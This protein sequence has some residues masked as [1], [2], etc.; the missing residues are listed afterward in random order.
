MTKKSHWYPLSFLGRLL[1]SLYAFVPPYLVYMEYAGGSSVL[2]RICVV[3]GM[4]IVLGAMVASKKS[5]QKPFL[6]KSPHSPE[7]AFTL[8][9]LLVVISII[10]ILAAI[11]LPFVIG[12]RKEAYFVRAK[13]E[14]R[15]IASALQI[16]VLNTNGQYPP[17]VSRD[18]PTGLEQYL[19]AGNWSKAPW[20][21]SVY[22][23][24]NWAPADLNYNPKAQ[25]YQISIRFCP[26]GEPENCN[27]PSEVWAEDFD[28]YSSMYYCIEGPCRSHSSK[29]QNHPGL[30]V[31]C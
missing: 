31:N 9:E 11:I 10:G 26:L 1:V 15:S 13:A 18:L 12:A 27:F 24:D 14:L 20:P 5:K 3:G 17:D 8:I 4:C 21:G 23:W 25:V 28:Y 30:C 29:P 2:L 7:G 6:K 22:D 16:Y 19:S